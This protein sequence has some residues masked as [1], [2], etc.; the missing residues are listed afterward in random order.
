[1]ASSLAFSSAPFVLQRI[2][3]PPEGP[4]RPEAVHGRDGWP[5][6]G[7]SSPSKVEDLPAVGGVEGGRG[8][9][10]RGAGVWTG[11]GRDGAESGTSPRERVE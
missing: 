7:L 6:G 4:S 1:M 9:S 10:R 5:T 3:P 2:G 8:G 11:M